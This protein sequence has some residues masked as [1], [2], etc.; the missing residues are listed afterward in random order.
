MSAKG[1]F[2]PYT[3]LTAATVGISSKIVRIT[4][5]VD[6]ALLPGVIQ[7]TGM[8]EAY[9]REARVRVFSVLACEKIEGISK[10]GVRLTIEPAAFEVRGDAAFD[11]AM[12]L[13]VL[14]LFEHIPRRGEEGL[15]G[16]LV[17]GELSLDAKIRP[18]RGLV[19]RIGGLLAGFESLVPAENEKELAFANWM[20]PLG[21]G[22]VAGD[23]ATV[24][25]YLR[26]EQLL[27]VVMG[28]KPTKKVDES[29]SWDLVGFQV[30]VAGIDLRQ[31]VEEGARRVLLMGKVGTG[32]TS[33]ARF[34]VGKLPPMSSNELLEATSIHSLAGLIRP[35]VGYVLGRPFRA[36][37]YSISEAGLVG[38]GRGT[39][40]PGEAAL[41]HAGVLFLDEANEFR[42]PVLDALWERLKRGETHVNHGSMSAI[43]PVRPIVIAAVSD[44]GKGY[45]KLKGRFWDLFEERINI[46]SE[47]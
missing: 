37:H 43:V 39:W 23:L 27:P 30:K 35:E 32:K 2:Q 20:L 14:G 4:A 22:R 17:L 31:K 18:V 19:A 21:P 29:Y 8:E 34:L 25:R 13:A 3:V 40:R 6:P 5:T 1:L 36:P 24:V 12:T 45:P 44:H 47:V 16:V 41:A 42:A 15:E 10:K 26:G 38:G 28:E 46:E 7:I 11:L 33:L 9:V